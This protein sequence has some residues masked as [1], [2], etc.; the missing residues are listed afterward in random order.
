MCGAMERPTVRSVNRAS[1][2]LRNDV[3]VVESPQPA[4]KPRGDWP[5]W[6]RPPLLW[7]R[8]AYLTALNAV[9]SG[10]YRFV[11][12]RYRLWYR[13]S[14]RSSPR[15][16]AL[17][18][19]NAYL[20]CALAKKRVPAYA[21]F[22]EDTGHVFRI[23]ELSAFPETTK[24][25]YVQRYGY[26]ERCRGGR[27]PIVGTVIDES[28]GSSGT[29]FN[30]LRSGRELRDV[31]LNTA[32][33]LRFTFPTERLLAINAF[34]MGAWATGTNMGIALS[35]VCMV[36]STGPDLDKVVSTIEL[37]GDEFDYL[38]TAYPPFLKHVVDALDERGFDWTRTRVYGAV[39]GEGMTEAMRDH[40][41]RRLV[42][43]RSGYGASDIQVG[44]AGET[45]L[46]VWVRK[47]LVERADV[48]AALL[49]EHESRIPMVFQ[50]NPLENYIEINE[51]GEAVIT[52][53][54]ASVLSPKLRYNVGDE[55]L[56]MKK[57]EVLRRLAAVGVD[58]PQPL[59]QSWAAPFFFLYGRR[60]GTVSYMG[61]NIYP[62]DVEYGL[63]RDETLAAAIESFCLE[64]EESPALESRPVVHVQLREGAAVNRQEAAER[65]RRGLV[66]YLA[67]ANQDFAESL[68]EDPSAAELRLVLHDHGAGPFAGMSAKIKN[69]YV[70]RP[71]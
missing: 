43:V 49:G 33:W 17:G 66:D 5:I 67:S 37:F 40:L 41:E 22:L 28:A 68:R 54:N 51:H 8:L 4:P 27:I 36:K 11:R 34:S 12:S 29:P 24:E 7:V 62:T 10:L 21:R 58:S 46:S 50:Y 44:I 42:K 2:P 13:L 35:K 9:F 65:L 26:A 19:L 15:I 6:S 69:V 1:R 64:L 48:R 63:Y 18:R 45:D 20:N 52:L 59:P 56:T 38:I 16:E 60:D 25:S 30:W 31:H 71:S 47:L 57:D 3:G 55:G 61:A 70:V 53:N 32:N 23:L 39:G 14:Q